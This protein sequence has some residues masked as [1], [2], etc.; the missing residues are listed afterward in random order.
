MQFPDY[1]FP[2]L[3]AA[4]QIGL[5]YLTESER[6]RY[7]ELAVFAGRGP[8]P[9]SAVEA[10]WAPRGLSGRR[11]SPTRRSADRRH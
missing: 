7:R 3:L 2:S 1:P 6:S 8:V 11:D 4:L 10:L 9:R 5:D